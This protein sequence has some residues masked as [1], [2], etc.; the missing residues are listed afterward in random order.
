MAET[1]EFVPQSLVGRG[2]APSVVAL[3]KDGAERVSFRQLGEQVQRLASGLI[4]AGVE[5][6]AP[7]ALFAP[8]RPEWVI[9]ALAIIDAGATVIPVDAQA[10]DEQLAHLVADSESRWV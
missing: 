8:S 2:D 4:A 1:L 6:G 9:A 10:G 3:T 7:V 5:R